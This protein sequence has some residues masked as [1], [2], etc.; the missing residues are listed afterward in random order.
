VDLRS[1]FMPCP[2]RAKKPIRRPRSSFPLAAAAL[3]FAA[4]VSGCGSGAQ[5]THTTTRATR[6]HLPP[7]HY[8]ANYSSPQDALVTRQDVRAA[9]ANSPYGALLRWWRALQ[10]KNLR[11]AR[12]AFTKS[13]DTSG[14][15]REVRR[16]S[17]DTARP[18]LL[19][20]RT[21]NGS[22]QVHAVVNAGK[23][24]R[25]NPDKVR[26][27]SQTPA[28]FQ[29]RRQGKRWKLTN[30]AYLAQELKANLGQ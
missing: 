26:Y 20:V 8:P 3:I 19:H 25:S 21:R 9:G 18:K 17:L 23:F 4:L 10:S 15:A 11:A 28:L 14:L 27:I 16:L 24:A 5:S 13:A 30:D 12:R 7:G 1:V 6:P 29:L 22:A 2:M